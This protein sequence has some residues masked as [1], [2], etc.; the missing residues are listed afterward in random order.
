MLDDRLDRG[1]HLGGRRPGADDGDDPSG[2]VVLV[3]PPCRVK[4]RALEVPQPGPV[5]VT[6]HVEE[7]HGADERVALIDAS[8]VEAHTPDV[9][10]V[11]PG[12]RL[13]RD[14]HAQLPVPQRAV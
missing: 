13:G 1:H 5:R 10:S 9:A 2:Q 6:G 14:A 4:R 11:V 8:V 12:G 7:A 3:L